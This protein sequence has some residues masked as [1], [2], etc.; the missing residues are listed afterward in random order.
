MASI[1][2]TKVLAAPG[3]DEAWFEGLLRWVLDGDPKGG[4]TSERFRRL[5]ELQEHLDLR[6]FGAGWKARI[7]AVWGHTSAVGLLADAGLPTHGSFLREAVELLVDRFVP[8]LDPENDLSALLHR[9][10]LD[11]ADADWL[12]ALPAGDGLWD[13]LLAVPAEARWDAVQLL[14]H[15]AAALG[16]ARDLLGLGPQERELDSPFARLPEAA[17]V[18][19]GGGDPGWTGLLED[20][21]RRLARAHEH[22]ESHGTSSELVYRLD[23]LEAHVERCGR[24]VDVIQGRLGGRAFAADL[25]RRKARARR[26]GTLVKGSLR[27][28]A[29]KVVEHTGRTGEHYIAES[30]GEWVSTFWSAAGGGALTAFTAFFKYALAAAAVAPLVGGLGFAAN[31]TLSFVAMQFLGLTLASKQPAMTAAS[32]AGALE[33]SRSRDGLRALVAGITRSQAMATAGNVLVT[34]PVTA[35]L[36]LAW[37]RVL[38][39]PF[40]D[41]ATAAHSLHGLHP[42]LSWTI[43]FA[44]LTG[45]LL[46]MSSLAAG[47]AA[48]WSAYRRLPEA[49]AGHRRLRNWLGPAGAEAL[50]RGVGRH[51]SGVVGYVA[52]GMLLGF[53]PVAFAFAGLRV[54]V[55]HVT[56]NA[57]SLALCAVQDAPRWTDIAWGLASIVLIGICNFGVSFHLALRTAMKARGVTGF[58]ELS[59]LGREFLKSPWTF[60]GPP[61]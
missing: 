20:C 54:E 56:L 51:F 16:L 21:R 59:W 4:L 1:L 12:E 53:L 19:R 47:W 31:Y 25:I 7:Q 36:A 14:A 55:R 9:L 28:M 37:M 29:R 15:R 46:W 8:S 52:L 50:G 2:L 40:V 43:P 18:L 24:L 35:V 38:G 45:V 61:R 30:R 17:A 42:F 26:L 57:A 44:I 49:V 5:Q 48:N 39:R 33:D 34:I 13:E 41:P 60:L 11:E 3:A 10:E 32:L 58:R 22:L 23:L 27:H 6:P